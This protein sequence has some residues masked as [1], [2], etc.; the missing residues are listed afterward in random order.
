MSINGN[1][2]AF[3]REDIDQAPDEPGVYGLYQGDDLI[4]IGRAEGGLSITTMRARLKSHCEGS[5]DPVARQRKLLQEYEQ[6][7]GRLPRYTT[8]FYLGRA[9]RVRNIFNLEWTVQV[10]GGDARWKR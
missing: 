9:R 5:R 10:K 2:Q 3:S 1:R 6:Q 7:Y 8:V 4:D